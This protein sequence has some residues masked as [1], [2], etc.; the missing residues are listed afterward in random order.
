MPKI[1]LLDTDVSAGVLSYLGKNKDVT[2][3]KAWYDCIRSLIA[4]VAEPR[5]AIPTPIFYELAARD[6]AMLE[7][8]AA[9]SSDVKRNAIFAYINHSITPH[10]LLE[11]AKYRVECGK[12]SKNCP[13]WVDASLAAYCFPHGHYLITMN[14]KD[15]P[16]KFFEVKRIC[17]APLPTAASERKVIFLLAPRP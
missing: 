6:A 9:I 5:L 11:A 7:A 3:A 16:D 10:T 2:K 14:Q 8:I 4:D 12:I 17:L 15:Y 13:S 1:V